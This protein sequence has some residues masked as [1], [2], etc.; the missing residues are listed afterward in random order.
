MN[1]QILFTP[2]SLLD[3]LSQIDELKELAIGLTV[4]LDGELVLQIGDS[5]YQIEPEKPLDI[6]VEQEVAEDVAEQNESAYEELVESSDDIY[7]DEE[8]I[9]GGIYTESIK[10][11]LV[12]G[13]V[14]LAGKYLKE[15]FGNG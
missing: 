7:V 15:N 9:E 11:M 14:R 8:I 2:A 4:G 3:L 10:N 6:E 1:E 13:L 5:T 12:G